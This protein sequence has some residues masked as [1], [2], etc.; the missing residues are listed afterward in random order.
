M[1]D[2]EIGSEQDGLTILKGV[3]WLELCK[4]Y[5]DEDNGEKLM[6]LIWIIW[7]D[8]KNHKLIV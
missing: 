3:E 4:K 2:L 5:A 8:G 6:E 7:N 1:L